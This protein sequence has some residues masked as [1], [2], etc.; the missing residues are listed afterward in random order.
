MSHATMVLYTQEAI[1]AYLYY[2]YITAEYTHSP[3][4]HAADCTN[5]QRL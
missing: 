4:I 1:V 5:I 3:L 2:K